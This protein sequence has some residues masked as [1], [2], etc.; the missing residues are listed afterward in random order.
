MRDAR[1]ANGVWVKDAQVR[2]EGDREVRADR[3]TWKTMA[4]LEVHPRNV[5]FRIGW[6]TEQ[7]NAAEFYSE[8]VETKDAKFA[9]EVGDQGVW[10]VA[11]AADGRTELTIEVVELTVKEDPRY[12]N[13]PRY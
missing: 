10:F 9:M 8:L 2:V 12:E 1:T 3:S 6:R 7:F 11:R 4:V 5:P 13:L